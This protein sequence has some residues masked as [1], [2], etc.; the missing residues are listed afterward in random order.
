VRV[1]QF[2]EPIAGDLGKFFARHETGSR[3]RPRLAMRWRSTGV[4]E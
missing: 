2:A 3:S 1:A 4:R